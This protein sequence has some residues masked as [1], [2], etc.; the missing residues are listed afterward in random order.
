M[1]GIVETKSSL[2]KWVVRITVALLVAAW[3]APT[4]GLFVSS[5]RTR[6][7]ISG[8]G[9]W[10][11]FLTAE[12]IQVRRAADPDDFRLADGDVFTVSGNLF[13]E[14][15]SKKITLWGTSSRAIDAYVPGEV[16]DLGDGESITVQANGDY[17]WRGNDDQ[18][19]G[20]GQ[21]VFVTV[22]APPEFT[23][24]NY[25]WM[26]FDEKNKKG[27]SQAFL[28]TLTMAIPSTIIPITIAAFAAYALAWMN[29]RGNALVIAAVVAGLA[30]PPQ[31]ALIPI[32][33]LHID[34]GIGK[35]FLGIW[36]AQSAGTMP[37]AIFLLYSYMVRIPREIVE[38]AKLDGANDFQIF[39]R[40]ILP[41]SIPALASY[42]I[43]QFLWVFNDLLG[44]KVFLIDS[45][46]GARDIITNAITRML[47]PYAGNWDIISA[48]AFISM[49]VPLA[50][51]FA[52]QRYF[53]RGLLA[54]SIKG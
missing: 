41:L 28:N 22:R 7:Q 30:V 35:S 32:L 11:A 19:S 36:L 2:K 54:G 4:L 26:L 5:F 31:V 50:V 52:M 14:G 42:A 37:F 25:R 44:P 27:M 51:F 43:I 53:A 21:R 45:G 12:Q 29:F 1:D 9:W 8:T 48:G 13:G 20:R 10:S 38:N 6:D 23:L 47:G 46:T 16:A 40:I 24:E 34:I 33:K 18:L 49:A 39:I 17:V 15:A 3:L